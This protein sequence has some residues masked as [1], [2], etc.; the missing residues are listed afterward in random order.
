MP[1]TS[2]TTKAGTRKL[3]EVAKHLAVPTGIVSTGWPGVHKTCRDKLGVTFDDWQVQVGRVILA[4]RDD[5]HLAAMIDGVGMSLPRQ[6]GK[7]YLVGALIFALCINQPGLLVIWTAH[8]ARTHGETFLAMQAFADRAK[9]KP[10]VR[11]VY[12][13]SGTE[14]VRFHNGSRILFGAREHGFGRGIPGVD[15]LIFDEAQILS[16]KALANMLATM[17]T[18]AFGLALFI[19]T[20]PRPVDDSEAFTRMRTQALAGDLADGAWIEFGCDDDADPEDRAQLAKANPS[21]PHRTPEQS[22]QRLKRK[23]TVDDFLREGMGRWDKSDDS[24][25]AIDLSQ[26]EN[27]KVVAGAQSRIQVVVDVAP[28]LTRST[29]SVTSEHADGRTLVVVAHDVGTGWVAE[30]VKSITEKATVVEVALTP[31][32]NIFAA[33]LTTAGHDPKQLTAADVGRGCPAF[34]EWVRAQ[35]VV[36]VGQPELAAA[37]RNARTRLVGGVLRWEPR[38]KGVD[39]SPIN[40]ASVG[41]QRWR[42]NTAIPN[43]SAY[44]DHDLLVL[45]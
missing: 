5:G 26:W 22:I 43:R 45:D 31:T 44:E 38:E 7:T 3:S 9:V 34:I 33:A 17:N 29:I 10:H 41:A 4:K 19:G 27:L 30:K 16:D 20:P 1:T 28:D 11:A 14:E 23:L 18:S 36:H 39:I 40:A 32:A 37:I 12:T 15:V 21:Y 24:R 8:H 2:P 13:G 6:V 25:A 35:S 42:L